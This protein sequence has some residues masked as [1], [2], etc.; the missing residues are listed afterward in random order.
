MPRARP[1]KKHGNLLEGHIMNQIVLLHRAGVCIIA[2]LIAANAQAGESHSHRPQTSHVH[3]IAALNLVVD[4]KAVHIELNSP[5]ANLVG[6]EHAPASE[7]EHSAQKNALLTL[8]NADQLFRF[9]KTA[10]CHAAQIEIE[11]GS[12]QAAR[13]PARDGHR[14]HESD[15]EEHADMRHSDITAIYRFTCDAPGEL[16]TLRVGLFDAFPAINNL[17]VQYISDGG[18]GA[19]TLSSGEPLLRF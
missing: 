19:A 8:K 5:A 7:A 9:N 6:F 16:D 11:S 3:G 1:G 18:Q 14:H 15:D 13:P 12:T 2:M 17:A 10:N 4:G